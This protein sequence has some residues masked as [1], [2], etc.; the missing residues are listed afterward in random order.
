MGAAQG[1]RV[2]RQDGVSVRGFAARFSAYL[3]DHLHAFIG[4]HHRHHLAGRLIEQDMRL[5]GLVNGERAGS[6]GSR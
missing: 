5:I 4:R 2:A 3:V 1:R 6:G